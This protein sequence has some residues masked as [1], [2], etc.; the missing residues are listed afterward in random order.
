M[1]PK[2]HYIDDQD[3]DTGQKPEKPLELDL[4]IFYWS[5]HHTCIDIYTYIMY[6]TFTLY[7]GLAASRTNQA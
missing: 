1:A 3:F 4:D 2:I 7:I 5:F 6:F